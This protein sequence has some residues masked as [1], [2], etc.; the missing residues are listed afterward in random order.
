LIW[1]DTGIDIE[2]E[3]QPCLTFI[4]P[5]VFRKWKDSGTVIA[6]FPELPSDIHG[7]YCVA[8]EHVGLFDLPLLPVLTMF[9]ATLRRTLWSFTRAVDDGFS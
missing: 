3:P 7:S 2:K 4:T 5:V 8:Y 1:L 9:S 6:L